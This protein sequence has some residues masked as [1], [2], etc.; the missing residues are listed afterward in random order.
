MVCR[1]RKVTHSQQCSLNY[2]EWSSGGIRFGYRKWHIPKNYWSRIVSSR[3]NNFCMCVPMEWLTVEMLRGLCMDR[4]IWIHMLST[5]KLVKHRDRAR[6]G[7][8]NWCVMRERKHGGGQLWSPSPRG[9]VT[10]ARVLGWL[11]A[12]GTLVLTILCD[13]IPEGSNVVR[14]YG[15]YWED[16]SL[17]CIYGGRGRFS[18]GF[19]Y[20]CNMSPTNSH[21]Y[22]IVV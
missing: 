5:L 21:I 4:C 7:A 16:S 19:I 2:C 8:S 3:S 6:V 22:F 13:F 12:C 20:G 11:V 18:R 1:V 14:P 10:T 17:T 9:W 15:E